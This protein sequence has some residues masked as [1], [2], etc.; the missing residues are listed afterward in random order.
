[1]T[2]PSTYSEFEATLSQENPPVD[3]PETLKSLWHQAKGNWE[4]SHDIAQDI[5]DTMGSLIHA[6]LH[7]DEGDDWNAGYWYRQAGRTFPTTSLK[8]ELREIVEEVLSG[9]R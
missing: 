3:W 1:M 9:L 2:T 8:E 6:H 5:H 7:R 4:A